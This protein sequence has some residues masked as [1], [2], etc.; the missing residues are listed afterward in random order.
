MMDR[1]LGLGDPTLNATLDLHLETCSDCAARATA[2]AELS[3]LLVGLR[4]SPPPAVD[5]TGQVMR[6]LPEQWSAGDDVSSRQLGWAA[7]SA[8]T[9]V[10]LLLAGFWRMLPSLADAAGDAWTTASSL[11][12][13]LA[14]VFAT[15]A[16]LASSIF[17]TTARLFGALAPLASALR[18]LEPVVIA[19]TALSA[20]IMAL[21]IVFVVG[22]DLRGRALPEKGNTI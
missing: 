14:A 16:T 4:S 3:A 8:V 11:R 19:A 21:T 9:V 2:E 15:A 18:G 20:T 7:A 10:A 13:S 17:E 12:H 1:E 22:R 5:V 6:N